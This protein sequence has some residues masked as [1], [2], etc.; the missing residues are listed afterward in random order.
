MGRWSPATAGCSGLTVPR[1]A[2]LSILP[3]GQDGSRTAVARQHLTTGHQRPSSLEE[4]TVTAGDDELMSKQT[5]DKA[6]DG[7]PPDHAQLHPSAARELPQTMTRSLAHTQL[8]SFCKTLADDSQHTRD[9]PAYNHAYDACHH[10][11]HASRVYQTTDDHSTSPDA[12]ERPCNRRYSSICHAALPQVRGG[13][14]TTTPDNS[15]RGTR[16]LL[17]LL[18]AVLQSTNSPRRGDTL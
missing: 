11:R 10:W 12:S 3:T 1:T 9:S 16:P 13:V 2:T 7:R 8:H 5:K 4:P 15:R 14:T 17:R 6:E 18:P